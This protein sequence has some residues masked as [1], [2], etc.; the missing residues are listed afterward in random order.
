[1][2]ADSPLIGKIILILVLIAIDAF[3][4][5]AE[6]AVISLDASELEKMAEE[7]NKKAERLLKFLRQ[8]AK[9]LTMIQAVITLCGF[10]ISAFTADLLALWMTGLVMEQF[11]HLVSAKVWHNI[12]LVL[13]TFLLSYVV[14]VFGILLPKRLA[15][16]RGQKLA[17]GSVL[18]RF[19]A[20]YGSFKCD[21]KSSVTSFRDRSKCRGGGSQRGRDT[22]NGRCRKQKRCDRSGGK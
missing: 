7:K 21:Y 1:M 10:L 4:S 15:A 17:S 13:I 22:E 14:L 16:K 8:P 20:V 12:F 18:D 3:C 9:F 5:C 19:F 6:I 11:T 2:I